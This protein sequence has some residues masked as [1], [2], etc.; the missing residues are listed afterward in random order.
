[1]TAVATKLPS[2]S[3]PV[4]V[5]VV[6]TLRFVVQL[7]ESTLYFRV[8]TKVDGKADTMYQEDPT[9]AEPTF[10]TAVGRARIEVHVSVA[11]VYFKQSSTPAGTADGAL[12]ATYK[13]WP[14]V[15]TFWSPRITVMGMAFRVTQ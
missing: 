14:S 4:S 3:M 15:P 13:H 1:M 10:L 6:G 7:S 9:T 5:R 12:A 2:L 8:P 11:T